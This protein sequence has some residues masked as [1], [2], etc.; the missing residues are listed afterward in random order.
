MQNNLTETKPQ[1]DIQDVG[2]PASTQPKHRLMTRIWHWVNATAIIIMFMSGLNIFNAHPRLYWGSDGT[3]GDPFW[4]KLDRFPGWITVPGYYSLADA[5]LWHFFFAWV[6][7]VGLLIFLLISLWNRHLQRDVHISRKEWRWSNIWIDIKE[8]AKLNF[9]HG[10]GKYNFLQK[11]TYALVLFVMIPLMIF[12]GITMSPGM[13][14]NWPFLLDIFGG[15][16]SAR[17]IHF[18]VTGALFAFFVVHILLVLLAGP[19]GQLRDM[20]TGGQLEAD[21]EPETHEETA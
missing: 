2:A 16:Q 11:F 19:I 10:G 9:E 13:N 12:T 20:I 5:R 15:R 21:I 18:I 8:H 14:A 4:L 6:L 3:W 7:S 17:S 1:Y